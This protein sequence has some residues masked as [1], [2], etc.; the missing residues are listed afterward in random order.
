MGDKNIEQRF[1]KRKN[2]KE[3]EK[4]KRK[5]KRKR[6][7]KKKEKERGEKAIT[8]HHKRGKKIT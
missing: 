3:K 8:K 6:K 2:K 5:R 7:R 4:G 1:K